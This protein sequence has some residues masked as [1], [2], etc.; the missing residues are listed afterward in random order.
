[1]A[2]KKPILCSDLPA[3]REIIQDGSNGVLCDVNDTNSWIDA[4][5]K[6]QNDPAF[7]SRITKNAF[8]ELASKYSWDVRAHNILDF[9]KHNIKT[10]D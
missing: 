7:T 9:L 1:M 4:I 6:L 10:K 8:N 2:L 3:L 5:H